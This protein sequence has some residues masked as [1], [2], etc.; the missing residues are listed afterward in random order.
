MKLGCPPLLPWNW[1]TPA[2]AQVPDG[3]VES[4]GTNREC[5]H[6]W[7]A[8]LLAAVSALLISISDRS[9]VPLLCTQSSLSRVVKRSALLPSRPKEASP[10]RLESSARSPSQRPNPLFCTNQVSELPR[11]LL[12][13]LFTE[14]VA[15]CESGAASTRMQR[16]EVPQS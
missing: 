9:A 16:S 4:S 11:V 10:I 13:R 5:A 7:S 2:L 3:S 12:V 1:R 6:H 15:N 8:P 14:G